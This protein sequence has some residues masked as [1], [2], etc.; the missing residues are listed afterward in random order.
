MQIFNQINA[1]KIE[2]GELN[3]FKG[4]FSNF[5]F[6]GVTVLTFAVQMYMVEIGGKPVKCFA[7]SED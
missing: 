2:L 5:L 6:L 4:F 1:R 3:V 7:L